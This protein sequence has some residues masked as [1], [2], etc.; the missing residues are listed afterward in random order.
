MISVSLPAAAKVA[1]SV[2]PPRTTPVP[3]AAPT[4]APLGAPTAAPVAARPAEAAQAPAVVVSASDRVQNF[5]DAIHIT[6]VR[7]S[8]ADSKAIVDGH[9]YRVN[10]LLDKALGIR[11]VKVDPDH[12]TFSDP[13]GTRY[14]KS[15]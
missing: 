11:L 12:L 5:I 6:G 9:I 10:E 7:Y 13:A 2:S 3:T 15:F 4:A 1:E 14:V 8:G